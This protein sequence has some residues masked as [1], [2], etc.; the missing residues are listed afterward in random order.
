MRIAHVHDPDEASPLRLDMGRAWALTRPQSAGNREAGGGQSKEFLMPGPSTERFF[1]SSMVR[2][3]SS[4]TGPAGRPLLSE[5]RPGFAVV[6]AIS[7]G[8]G[9]LLFEPQ[10]LREW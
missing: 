7:K 6:G 1:R 3:K 4:G 5:C 9:Q 8:V 2:L 10:A